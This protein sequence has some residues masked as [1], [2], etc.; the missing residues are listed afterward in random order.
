MSVLHFNLNRPIHLARRDAFF[1]RAVELLYMPVQEMDAATRLAH[2]ERVLNLLNTAQQHAFFGAR[3]PDATQQEHDF[4]HFLQ[5]ISHNL[6]S[7]QSM[8]QHQSHLEG[9]ASFLCQFL[10]AKPEE[11]ALPAL[12]YR[13]RADDILQ[14]L[15]HLL[16]LAHKPYRE[17]QQK[18]LAGLSDSEKARYKKA[19]QSFREELTLRDQMADPVVV[20]AAPA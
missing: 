4:L 3:S 17:L 9:E 20:Q 1:E 2:V 5:L 15:W 8:T 10:T 11:C 18:N 7:A 13:R 6:Q 19:Y 12:H 14:G 16:R